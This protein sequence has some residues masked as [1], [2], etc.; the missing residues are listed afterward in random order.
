MNNIFANMIFLK[1]IIKT[2]VVNRRKICIFI[3]I[4]INLS[5]VTIYR[6]MCHQGRVKGGGT[7]GTVPGGPLRIWGPSFFKANLLIKEILIK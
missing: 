4:F 6:F 7:P 3:N 5:I 2:R 1:D